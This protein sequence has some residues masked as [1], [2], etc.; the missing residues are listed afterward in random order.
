MCI[1]DMEGT[2]ILSSSPRLDIDHAPSTFTFW[3]FMIEIPLS[4]SEMKISYSINGGLDMHFYVPARDQNM[5]FAA[6]SVSVSANILTRPVSDALQCNGFSAGVNPD[7]FRGPGFKSGYDPVWV[8][9]LA[10]H[11]E[12]PFH[13]LVGGGDQLYCDS[14]VREPE[15]Q[16][17]VNQPRPELKEAYALTEEMR[18]AIDRFWQDGSA[19]SPGTFDLR[20]QR[21]AASASATEPSIYSTFSQMS[22]VERSQNLRVA[23]MEPHLRFMVGPLLRYDTVD[24]QGTWRGAAMVVSECFCCARTAWA[25]NRERQPR[26]PV[27]CTNLTRC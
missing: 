16:D 12:E 26:T 8:D 19:V 2:P 21:E 18:V 13:A 6:Y 17:W 11:A 14:L 22:A 7:D 3:R 24:A 4:S 10:H 9:L 5:R 27:R 20:L 15:M 23:R 1:M 25:S